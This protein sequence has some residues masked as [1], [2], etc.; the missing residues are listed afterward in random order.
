MGNVSGAEFYEKAVVNQDEKVVKEIL[1]NDPSLAS[2]VDAEGYTVLQR[3]CAKGDKVKILQLL[4]KN[5]ASLDYQEPKHLYTALMLAAKSGKTDFVNYLLKSN[6]N[7]LLKSKRGKSAAELTKIAGLKTILQKAESTF[8][9]GAGG[10]ILSNTDS[11]GASMLS[12]Q[13]AL[14]PEGKNRRPFGADG[15]GDRQQSGKSEVSES[16]KRQGS[17]LSGTG[18][19]RKYEK[20]PSTGRFTGLST[21]SAPAMGRNLS[22][23]TDDGKFGGSDDGSIDGGM[24]Q[25]DMTKS[26]SRSKVNDS[27]CNLNTCDLKHLERWVVCWYGC[28]FQDERNSGKCCRG[29]VFNINSCYDEEIDFGDPH[30]FSETAISGEE[31]RQYIFSLEEEDGM[32]DD[33]GKDKDAD[34]NEQGEAVPSKGVASTDIQNEIMERLDV[35]EEQVVELSRS[36]EEGLKD[37][38][39]FAYGGNREVN[40]S[41]CLGD[42]TK[43]C[44]IS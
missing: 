12:T 3:L 29:C 1:T 37:K 14:Q 25:G 4:V 31:M 26:F 21:P 23:Y 15:K 34:V 18:G 38:D 43:K 30:D 2:W 44:I 19:S 7:P 5:G 8:D 33:D 24:Q 35:L 42:K 28:G 27:V 39:Y 6:A 41:S 16:L 9:E 20:K 36:V 22:L 11:E 13:R 32:E 40:L 17:G 10:E